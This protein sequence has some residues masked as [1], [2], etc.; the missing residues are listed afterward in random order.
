VIS[1]FP[2]IEVEKANDFPYGTGSII[3]QRL[4]LTSAHNLYQRS[5]KKRAQHIFFQPEAE[6]VDQKTQLIRV[7]RYA[8]HKNFFEAENKMA[9]K[10]DIAILILE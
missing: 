3:G 9:Q 6:S 2:S 8:I 1:I 7:K 10:Y 5:S 4:I